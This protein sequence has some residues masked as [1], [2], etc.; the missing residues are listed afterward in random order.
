MSKY[1]VATAEIS[2]C[3]RYRYRLDRAWVDEKVMRPGT[4][5][6]IMLNPSTADGTTDD[7][8]IRRCVGFAK[9]W[10]YNHLVV[11]N[12]FAFRATDPATLLAASDPEGP[13]A[14]GHI[15]DACVVSG[16]IVCAWGEHGAHRDRDRFVLERIT[17]QVHCLAFTKSGLIRPAAGIRGDADPVRFIPK[18][19]AE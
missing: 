12:L 16:L 3:G 13:D 11:V 7:P 6:F 18:W 2:P 19:R 17:H 1:T 15:W 14:M 10:S 4:C 5:T 8:T 9:R